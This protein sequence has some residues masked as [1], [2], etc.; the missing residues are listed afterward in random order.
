MTAR[1]LDLARQAYGYNTELPPLF[2]LSVYNA[3][4]NNGVYVRPHL[5]KSLI[6][7]DGRDSV[8]RGRNIRDS[9]CSPR[10]ARMV[11]ECIR[12]V[13]WGRARYSAPRAR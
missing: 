7:E 8:L 6:D 10:T 1:H 12:E 5:V 11:R 3:I 2:T 9:I 4:A 13:V